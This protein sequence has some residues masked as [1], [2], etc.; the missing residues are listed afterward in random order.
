ME[1]FT[2]DQRKIPSE[3]YEY[4]DHTADVQL[5]AWGDN[6]KEAFEQ[7][8]MA[9]FAYMTEI[10]TVEIKQTATIEA[11]ADDLQNLLFHFLDEL[12]FVFSAE[13]YLIARKLEITEF[14]TDGDEMKVS[15]TCYG[16]EF[17]I[18]KHPQGTE[19]KA[20]T[21]SAMQI[22]NE[23]EQNKLFIVEYGR[24]IRWLALQHSN[25]PWNVTSLTS[26][27]LCH[28]ARHRYGLGRKQTRM[29]KDSMETMPHVV[30]ATTLAVDACKKLFSN[31]RWNCS[32]I[33]TAP[34]FTQDLTRGTREQ[35]YVYALSSAAM[36]YTMA[37]ACASGALFHCTCASPPHDPPSGNFKWGGCGDNVRW[38]AQFAKQFV[39]SI[40]RNEGR[41]SKRDLE[42]KEQETPQEKKMKRIKAQL[43]AMNLHNN[44]VGRRI[45]EQSLSIQCKCHGV[46]GSCNIKTCW[47]ALPSLQDVGE[48]LQRRFSTAVEVASRR[49]GTGKRLLPALPGRYPPTADQ[50]IYITKSPDYCTKDV[51]LGSFGTAGRICNVS[52]TGTDSCR[53]M[54]CGRGYRTV[55]EEKIERC[56]CKYYWCCYV[57]CKTCRTLIQTHECN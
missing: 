32:S 35:A 37:R 4:L 10:H 9:M 45:V 39:D 13:P 53:Y 21:Y 19:V 5:H 28:Q 2:E 47:R 52:S 42:E 43:S 27:L 14:K 50:L 34:D 17:Q 16:E 46:S 18:G 6:L 33:E 23:P 56:H 54:C 3:K 12:L 48:H 26:R 20:I 30:S 55:V 24:A 25:I 29:C 1:E 51:R 44:R 31:R 22:I 36:T 11:T 38:G 40:E 7:C 57:K 15:C 49:L 41:A 8:G